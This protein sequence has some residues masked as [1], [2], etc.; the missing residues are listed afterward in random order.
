MGAR[1]ETDFLNSDFPMYAAGGV[2]LFI[3]Y[4]AFVTKSRGEPLQPACMSKGVFPAAFFTFVG[5]LACHEMLLDM[6][7]YPGGLTAWAPAVLAVVACSWV[8]YRGQLAASG[9]ELG[10]SVI[11]PVVALAAL[12]IS[13]LVADEVEQPQNL[14]KA[15]LKKAAKD[16]AKKAAAGIGAA[17]GG[18]MLYL[19]KGKD[20]VTEQLHVALGV[21]VV[22]VLV[23]ALVNGP[24]VWPRNLQQGAFPA[25]FMIA[26]GVLAY[27]S[28][29]RQARESDG[30]S[31]D[32]FFPAFAAALAATLLA[33]KG[34]AMQASA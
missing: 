2:T 30:G 9:G 29:L 31:L 6:M 11:A 14:T 19:E 1:N 24:G 28:F 27:N 34:S 13:W 5:S 16:A 22:V 32:D 25:C 21:L 18:K 26:S 4:R 7:G 33:R 15:Q 12:T 3:I 8:A 23:L 20:V 10:L 17:G